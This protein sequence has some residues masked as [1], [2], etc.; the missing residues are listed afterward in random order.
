MVEPSNTPADVPSDVPP[1]GQVVRTKRQKTDPSQPASDMVRL[2]PISK[3]PD[4]L[5]KEWR[6]VRLNKDDLAP[7]MTLGDEQLSVTS[8]KGYRMVCRAVCVTEV[9]TCG[10]HVCCSTCAP[11]HHASTPPCFHTNTP[12]QTISHTHTYTPSCASPG[13][14]H[15]WCTQRHPLLRGDYH[16]PG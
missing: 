7:G 3:Q 6:P 11:Y 15:P 10:M 2:I 14:R 12:S 1:P 4:V 16:T 5:R 13:T 9:S 8:T